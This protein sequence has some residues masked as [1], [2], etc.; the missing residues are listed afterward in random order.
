MKNRLS[1]VGTG[2][3]LVLPEHDSFDCETTSRAAAH[4]FGG[5][6]VGLQIYNSCLGSDAYFLHF[7]AA[8]NFGQDVCVVGLTPFDQV[9]GLYPY[10]IYPSEEIPQIQRA[11]RVG[12]DSGIGGCS[13]RTIVLGCG[14]IPIEVI[15]S[16]DKSKPHP[17]LYLSSLSYN[18]QALYPYFSLSV[19]ACAFNAAR[20]S[21]TN[22]I[23]IVIK[24]SAELGSEVKE[25]G[26]QPSSESIRALGTL[27]E[28]GIPVLEKVFSESK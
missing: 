2:C 22:P 23:N 16:Q 24:R 10:G 8:I 1:R 15:T 11:M 4:E 6:V 14:H 13:P 19:S 7:V 21:F 25:I 28:R 5:S 27:K 9:L 17:F 12:I 26:R 20:F 3:Q 18:R